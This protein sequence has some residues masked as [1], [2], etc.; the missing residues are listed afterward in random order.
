MNHRP[1]MQAALLEAHNAPFRLAAV[2]RSAPGAGEALVR[3]A[4]SA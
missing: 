2:A 3:I 4:A 1:T